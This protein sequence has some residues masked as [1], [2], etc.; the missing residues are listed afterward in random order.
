MILLLQKFLMTD[1]KSPDVAA[2]T[3]A[4]H[5]DTSSDVMLQ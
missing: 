1:L 5:G 2:V 4:C 3:R